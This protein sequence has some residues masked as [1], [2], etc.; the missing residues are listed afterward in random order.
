[1]AFE[2]RFHEQFGEYFA[3]RTGNNWTAVNGASIYDTEFNVNVFRYRGLHL[4]GPEKWVKIGNNDVDDREFS[5]SDQ[6]FTIAVMFKSLGT[7]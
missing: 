2:Y 3:D 4:N 5:V 1:M 7:S 6:Y